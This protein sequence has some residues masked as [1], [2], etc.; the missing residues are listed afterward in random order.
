MK[1]NNF[2]ISRELFWHHDVISG[3]QGDTWLFLSAQIT[4]FSVL[5]RVPTFNVQ[6]MSSGKLTA[7]LSA[8]HR[9]IENRKNTK[10]L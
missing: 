2:D 5:L 4:H 8:Y 1:K 6:V 7:N 3:R 9:S 10:L